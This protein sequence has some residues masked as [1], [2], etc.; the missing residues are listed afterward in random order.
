VL[1]F[2]TTLNCETLS[3]R[4]VKMADK[5]AGRALVRSGSVPT[6]YSAPPF[7]ARLRRVYP[8][9]GRFALIFSILAVR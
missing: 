5:S 2:V 1:T 3:S 9:A 8:M 6:S 7:K 4:V